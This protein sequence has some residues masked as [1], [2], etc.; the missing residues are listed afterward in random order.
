MSSIL[1]LYLSP[2]GHSVVINN[3]HMIV[4]YTVRYSAETFYIDW[5]P[6]ELRKAPPLPIH[7]AAMTQGSIFEH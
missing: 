5:V 7:Q 3:D 1:S 2:S 4:Q 6:W